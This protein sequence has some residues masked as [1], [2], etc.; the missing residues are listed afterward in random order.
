MRVYVYQ[1]R[2]G[3]QDEGHFFNNGTLNDIFGSK[4]DIKPEWLD[5]DLELI[6]DENVTTEIPLKH[7]QIGSFVEVGGCCCF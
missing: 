7:I 5:D 1:Q 2:I 6:P 3:V 4:T